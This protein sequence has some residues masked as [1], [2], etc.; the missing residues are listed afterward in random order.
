MIIIFFD[1]RRIVHKEF[2]PARK[3]INQASYKDVL[4]KLRKRIQRVR[5]DISHDWI[6]HNDNA[7]AHTVL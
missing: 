3:T 5:K 1:S 6:L 4:K 7:P 2:L